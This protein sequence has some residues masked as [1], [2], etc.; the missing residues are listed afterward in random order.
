MSKPA[1]REW[2]C[3]PWIRSSVAFH[4][5]IMLYQ[6]VLIWAGILGPPRAFFVST[7]SNEQSRAMSVI[8]F[9]NR[10]WMPVCLP[11]HIQRFMWEC[12]DL[13]FQLKNTGAASDHLRYNS[14]LS[15]SCR[16]LIHPHRALEFLF[17]FC[18]TVSSVFSDICLFSIFSICF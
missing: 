9:I 13:G 14:T 2:W 18:K 12:C 6:S 5:F 3:G 8:S 10:Q 16:Q 1:Q 15:V 4:T 7:I 11:P 17:P